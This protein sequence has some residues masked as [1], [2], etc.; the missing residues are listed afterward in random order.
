M[1]FN[2]VIILRVAP[3]RYFA[4][5]IFVLQASSVTVSPQKDVSAEPSKTSQTFNE[6]TVDE[7]VRKLIELNKDKLSES[8]LVDLIASF[9]L[10]TNQCLKRSNA[11]SPT[12]VKK[13]QEDQLLDEGRAHN[14]D[15]ED[16]CKVDANN[17]AEENDEK[18][19]VE[20]RAPSLE[21]TSLR[22][23]KRQQWLSERAEL[24]KLQ[25]AN[26][27]GGVMGVGVDRRQPKTSGDGATRLSGATPTTPA[28]PP[29]E[30]DHHRF[31]HR[32]YPGGLV[33]GEDPQMAAELREKQRRQWLADLERQIEEKRL[34][35]EREKQVADESCS[36]GRSETPVYLRKIEAEGR[37]GGGGGGEWDQASHISGHDLTPARGDLESSF[38]RGRGMADLQGKQNQ[39][40]MTKRQQQME[41]HAVYAEQ[42]RE[43]AERRRLEKEQE[44]REEAEEA[45]RIEEERERLRREQAAEAS[46]RREIEAAMHVAMQEAQENARSYAA[47][48]EARRP[49][50]PSTLHVDSRS[51]FRNPADTPKYSHAPSRVQERLPTRN[52]RQSNANLG[53][54]YTLSN[55]E[56][57]HDDTPQETRNNFGWMTPPN[58][59]AEDTARI[60]VIRTESSL[61]APPAVATKHPSSDFLSAITDPDYAQPESPGL[62]KPSA[63]NPTMSSRN[64][65]LKHVSRIKQNLALRQHE[66][67]SM[68]IGDGETD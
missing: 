4:C 53:V 22:E 3:Q 61:L 19:Q 44:A 35:R 31:Q 24:E 42:I 11:S 49:H 68:Q 17:H 13:N 2:Y 36:S 48:E 63:T 15:N 25:N 39:D 66:L 45:A 51:H 18:D 34:A 56:G 58:E 33:I 30:V 67:R 47:R 60:G 32:N 52:R 16:A 65:A 27:G 64:S 7:A 59:A 37:G 55:Q 1:N 43:K 23:R 6:A 29:V 40:V 8:Q 54:T 21:F 62:P 12:Q 57:P 28:M 14:V 9:Y 10:V 20:Q 50:P 46:R 26:G 5:C 38:R 41:L